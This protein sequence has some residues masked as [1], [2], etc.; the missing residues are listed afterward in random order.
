MNYSFL[1]GLFLFSGFAFSVN[2]ADIYFNQYHTQSEIADFLRKEATTYPERVRF[3]VMGKSRQGREIAYVVISNQNPDSVPAIYLNGTHHG[4]EWSSTESILGLIDYLVMHASEPKVASLL[5]HYAIYLQPLVNPD[6]HAHSS[7]SDSQGVDPNRDYSYPERSEE[8]SFKVPE[9]QLV[10]SLVDRIQP[11][12]A[13][14]Y[15]SGIE[16]VLWP[17]CFTEQVS[18]DEVRL[19]KIAEASAKAMGFDRYL[20]SYFDYATEGEFIDYTYQK[21]GTAAFTFEVSESKTPSVSELTAVVNRS[22]EGAMAF[23]TNLA[24]TQSSVLSRQAHFSPS[25]GKMG[26]RTGVRLE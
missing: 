26:V 1:M 22:I 13:A 12:G 16:E 3:K 4:D 7:R 5:D 24:P 14:A 18:K 9:I 19:G 20:Q 10:K 11:V 8:K 23:M 15:H 25:Y 21:F 17:W 2:A 6:G